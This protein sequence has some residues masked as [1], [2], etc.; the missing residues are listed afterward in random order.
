MT[1]QDNF[2]PLNAANLNQGNWRD[3]KSVSYVSLDNNNLPA[4]ISGKTQ[5]VTK[6]N[7][8]IWTI[9]PSGTGSAF[10]LSEGQTGPQGSPG[11]QGSQGPQG[12]PGVSDAIYDIAIRTQT[13]FEQ[14]IASPTWLN[15]KSVAFIGDGGTLMFTLSTTNNGGVKIPQTVKQIHGYNSAKIVVTN[16]LYNSSTAK[17][18]LWYNTLP[19]ASDYSI[20]DLILS[21]TANTAAYGFYNCA[22]LTNCT[23]S[24]TGN[25]Y[26]SSA[27]GFY[28]CTRL[29]NCASSS[30]ASG[31]ADSFNSC[32]QLINCT[33][34][35]Y[36][37]GFSQ[38]YANC[39]QLIN[40]TGNCTGDSGGYAFKSCE[41]LTNCAGTGIGNYYNNGYGFYSCVWVNGCK[42]GASASTNGFTG[43]TMRNV[44]NATVVAI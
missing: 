7:G 35:D 27:C 15:A 13:Q 1:F 38:S 5:I 17:G 24:V 11:P 32:S 33:A 6:Q 26:N 21:C 14:L 18:G 8:E 3:D 36:S 25:A 37:D 39:K 43:G 22:R 4:A 20:S 41:Q 29:T 44:D 16:F 2:T 12:A 34:N 31:G 23:V 30:I 10:K 19:A 9:P 28:N 42:Q 40:C